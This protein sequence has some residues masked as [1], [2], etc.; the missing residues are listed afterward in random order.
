MK[1]KTDNFFL[2]QILRPYRLRLMV[3][4]VLTVL[5]SVLQ[6]GMALLT[7]FVIDTAISGDDGLGMWAALLAADLV[8]QVG[9]YAL[10]SWYTGS[11]VDR[12][13]AFLRTRLLR[14]AVYSDGP[15]LQAFHS[16]ELL[17]RGMEDVNT[18]C[19]GVVHAM[20]GLVGQ[21]TRLM[22]AFGAVVLIS[23]SVSGVLLVGGVSVVAAITAL[24]P[25]LRARHRTVREAEEKVM[26]TMQEDLQ[27]LELIQS[28]Q[29]QEQIVGRFGQRLSSSLA[30]KFRRRIWSVGSYSFLSVASLL[31]TGVLLLW[32]ASNVAAGLLSY[33]SLTSMLQL[34]S[35]FRGPV[36]SLS[37][38]WTRFAAVDVAGERLAEILE[39]PEQAEHLAVKKPR[40]IVF[41]NVTFCYPGDEVAVV[42]NFSLRLPL[43]GWSSL[44]G[45]SGRG[46]TTLFKLILGLYAPQSGRVYLETE[47][48]EIP[49]SAAT[50]HLFAYVPQDYALFSGT[51]RDNLLLVAPDADEAQRQEALRA[52]AADFVFELAQG[53]ESHVGENNTGLSK[54]QLQR[55][56]IARA[57]LMQR[58]VLLL[59]ECTSALDAQ[60]ERQVLERLRLICPSAILVT[61]RP[62]ALEEIPGVKAIRMEE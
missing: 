62:E 56:A 41:E 8:L 5:Q 27:Q 29:A 40:A 26:S 15:R 16:G 49:C 31:G 52:A 2:K 45:I 44:S 3:L 58:S 12:L 50:R 14:S 42:E 54:G 10:L 11:T 13:V 19:D 43:E 59:D 48:E 23:P 38:L 33:G 21:V 37:G 61:H 18:V 57:I 9:V 30:E 39:L 60:T 55:I 32:G 25:V 17:S 35:Q 47:G 34:L 28:I 1:A 20:P 6:V 36:L 24:R 53:E 7:R 22:A 46:K 51:I 4:S